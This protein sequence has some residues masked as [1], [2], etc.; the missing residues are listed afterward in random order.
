MFR[1]L[2]QKVIF[3]VRDEGLT[4]NQQ[5]NT[6]G[7]PSHDHFE[8]LLKPVNGVLNTFQSLL[9][10]LLEEFSNPFKIMLKAW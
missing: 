6:S 8:G 1:M 7:D 9:T 5:I 3:Q 10:S 2:L 4:S